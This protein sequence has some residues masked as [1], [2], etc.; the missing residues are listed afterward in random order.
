MVS[1][2][3]RPSIVFSKICLDPFA[4]SDVH[5]T[6]WWPPPLRPPILLLQSTTILVSIKCPDF[7]LVPIASRF[8]ITPDGSSDIH[9]F[10]WCF[11]FHPPRISNCG[12]CFN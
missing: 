4:V 7:W 12:L 1:I 9:V 5:P 10:L 8:W 3:F 2:C 11:S 6:L